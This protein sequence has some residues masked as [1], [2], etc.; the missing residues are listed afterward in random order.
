MCK[1]TAP[2]AINIVAK[3]SVKP[4]IGIK[5]GKI[6]NGKMKYPKAKIMMF[7]AHCGVSESLSV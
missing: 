2:S 7:L 6:S 3:S 5:S 4:V 1:A